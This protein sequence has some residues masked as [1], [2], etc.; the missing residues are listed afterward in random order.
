MARLLRINEFKTD[1]L[2]GP[3]NNRHVWM[4][5]REGW[6]GTH[7]CFESSALERVYGG[8][9]YPALISS[10]SGEVC[11]VG[12]K[13]VAYRLRVDGGHE[14]Y[15]NVPNHNH[16]G[17]NVKWRLWTK[18]PSEEQRKNTPWDVNICD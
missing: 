12:Y 13:G 18:C 7:S 15:F 14:A 6:Y 8:K 5:I 3:K 11:K 10:W 9:P 16:D 4:E 1:D 2:C 17:Y